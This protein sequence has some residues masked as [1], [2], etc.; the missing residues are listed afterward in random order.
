MYFNSYNTFPWNYTY[1]TIGKMFVSL[2]L[3]LLGLNPNL[4]LSF[5]SFSTDIRKQK[6]YL[7][8]EIVDFVSVHSILFFIWHA[9][10]SF[11]TNFNVS[12]CPVH[13]TVI[14]D[15]SLDWP[16]CRTKEYILITDASKSQTASYTSF[17]PTYG[18]LAA[19][20]SHIIIYIF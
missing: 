10:Q 15:I 7:N 16:D 4:I 20:V 11:P 3:N 6:R 19:V 8:N 2:C 13:L 9:I 18:P 5:I 14:T 17:I 1:F 12:I